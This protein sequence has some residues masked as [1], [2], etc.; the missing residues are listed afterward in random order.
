MRYIVGLLLLLLCTCGVY[1][2][3]QADPTAK[4]VNF[5]SKFFTRIQQ[6]TSTLSAELTRQTEKYLT[7]LAKRED[8][9]RRKIAKLDSASAANLPPSQYAALANKLRMDSGRAVA[10]SGEYMPGIDSLK[11]G[12]SFLSQNPNILGANSAMKGQLRKS[13]TQ[14]NQLQ[15]K[16]QD[17][18]AIKQYVQD[19]QAQ[20]K[21][22][23]LSKFTTLP[24]GIANQTQAIRQETYY[25]SAQ[26]KE[27]KDM[28]NSP[29]QLTEKALAILEKLP[30][31]QNY[32]KANGQLGSLFSLPGN[33][34]STTALEGLQNKDQVVALMTGQ[35]S[36]GG[37]D[38][39]SMIQQNVQ[40]GQSQLDNFKNK[41]AA[42]GPGS[43][44][45]EMPN[46]K[47]SRQKTKTF[48]KRLEY[49]TD[50]QT[51]STS[52][53]FPTTTDLG[54]N[55]GYRVSD[56]STIGIGAAYKI[57]WGNGFQHMAL[58]SQGADIRSFIDV[59][60]KGGFSATAG[61][62][63]NYQQLISSFQQI[64]N[65]SDWSKSGLVGISKA[66][67][68]KNSVFKQTKLQLLWDVLSFSQRPRSQPFKFRVGYSF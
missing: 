7:K 1:A 9:L 46:F 8:K 40:A 17:A 10:S 33:Y 22:Y 12:L 31:F 21:Q 68:M 5:P 6:K 14:F 20:I 27:Y 26:L 24:P 37:P 15:A 58:S 61:L 16:M 35:F 25:L 62:E 45:M 28:L 39:L 13:F 50:F 11:G 60:I 53:Y 56:K 18:D 52:Y 38:P 67:S 42:L 19:R 36:G 66:V 41:L 29:D 64:R 59:K 44:D 63:Y 4:V 32:M 57:G 43:G 51:T 2:Q 30:Q 3:D 48:L 47:P 55:V 34:N 65:L 54:L 23:L 49:S